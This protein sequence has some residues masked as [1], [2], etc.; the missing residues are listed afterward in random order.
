M[1][2]NQKVKKPF[3]KKWWFWVIIGLLVIAMVGGGNGNDEEVADE[4]E[5]T[6]EVVEPEQDESLEEEE[7]LTPE[8]FVISIIGEETNHSEEELKNPIIDVGIN[9]EAF[10]IKLIG[11]DNFSTSYIKGMMLIRASEIY[12][13]A[14]DLFPE[15]NLTYIEWQFPLVDTYGNVNLSPV[16]KIDMT[17]ETEDKINWDNFLTDNLPTVADSYWQHPALSE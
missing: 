15:I 13:Q 6:V 8:S 2:T 4:P 17:R 16:M 3:W 10:N 12:E 5:E 11:N 1:S 9:G 7:S 14:F